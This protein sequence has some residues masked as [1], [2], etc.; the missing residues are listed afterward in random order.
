M[1]NKLINKVTTTI[2]EIEAFDR[3]LSSIINQLNKLT[4]LTLNQRNHPL[5][6]HLISAKRNYYFGKRRLGCAKATFAKFAVED[7]QKI[8]EQDK[9][10]YEHFVKEL[11]REPLPLQNYFG[12]RL[13]LKM[14]ASLFKANISFKKT[15]TP[16][17]I[18]TKLSNVGIECTSAHINLS[19]IKQPTQ[20]LYK[21]EAALKNKS[22]YTY[23]TSFNILAVDVSN[24]LFHEGQEKCL[25]IIAD[26]DK[27][28]PILTPKVNESI[29][30]SLLY[31]YY[32]ATPVKNSNGVTLTSYYVRIDRSKINLDCKRFLD[33]K[34]PFGDRWVDGNLFKVV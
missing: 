1:F 2:S 14:A 24:L 9:S 25:A 8:L 3:N 20:V 4:G 15:E 23:K 22:S 34:Y 12:L 10:L 17:F 19:S 5:V 7:L 21:I 6:Q 32:V 30:Q 33:I 11:R 26:M 18:L 27:S 28:R 29:F 31:F 13:E 16:D